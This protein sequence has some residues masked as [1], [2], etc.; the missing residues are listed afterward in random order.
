MS[1][2]RLRAALLVCLG[3]IVLTGC[4][5]LITDDVSDDITED[6]LREDVNESE[7][8]ESVTAT[9]ETEATLSNDTLEVSEDLWLRSDGTS[10]SESDF[11][12]NS[13]TTVDDG[14]KVWTYSEG[15]ETVTAMDSREPFGSRLDAIYDANEQLLEE[16]EAA[17]LEETTVGDHDAYRVVLE[18]D[19]NE[20]IGRS[21]DV[22]MGDSIYSVPLGSSDDGATGENLSDEPE[23]VE[24]WLDQEYLFPVKYQFETAEGHF[25][26]Q[27]QDITF[28]PDLSDDLF[29]FEPPEDATVEEVTIPTRTEFDT[30]DQAD[31]AVDFD[32]SKPAHVPESYELDGVT[33]VE[34]EDDNRTSVQSTYIGADDDMFTVEASDDPDALEVDGNSVRINDHDGTIEQQ[35]SLGTIRLAWTCNDVSYYVGGST[36]LGESAIVSIA[37]SIGC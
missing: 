8:P 16:F 6:D 24:L 30:V 36:D 12:G 3:L 22:A 29:E 10:R 35:D 14:T 13:T 18:A 21:I 17:E 1:R 4:A 2:L 31:L 11:G 15:S 26:M 23:Q 32:V 25:R 37:E 5:G 19:S 7:P 33:V 28:E 34:Y 27:Y 9:L 20:S